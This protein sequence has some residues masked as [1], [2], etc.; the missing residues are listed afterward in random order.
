MKT[1]L[2]HLARCAHGTKVAALALLLCSGLLLACAFSVRGVEE[3]EVETP[4]CVLLA[5][6]HTHIRSPLVRTPAPLV[7]RP[8]G[9]AIDRGVQTRHGNNEQ[10]RR[11]GTGSHLLI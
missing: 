9:R 11:N 10:S 4:A 7:V 8:Q 1:F 2:Q 6:V 3:E 5:Q